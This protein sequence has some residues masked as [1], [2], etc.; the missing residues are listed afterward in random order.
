M[1]SGQC[2]TAIVAS[3][4]KA[5][6]DQMTALSQANAALHGVRFR[7]DTAAERDTIV[8]FVE[9]Y[10]HTT[11]EDVPGEVGYVSVRMLWM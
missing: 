7:Y 1:S 8:A 10:A 9:N 3:R 6:M 4:I 11:I 2:K 5:E